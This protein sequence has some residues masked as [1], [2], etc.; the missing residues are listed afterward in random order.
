[1]AKTTDK[2][3]GRGRKPKQQE[4][5]LNQQEGLTI[6]TNHESQKHQNEKDIETSDKSIEDIAE[7]T[8]NNK[9]IPNIYLT[10][11]AQRI[12]NRLYELYG[13]SIKGDVCR[14]MIQTAQ[15]YAS[16]EN[17]NIQDDIQEIKIAELYDNILNILS[18]GYAPSPLDNAYNNILITAIIDKYKV[19]D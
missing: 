12:M 9:T 13:Y 18:R 14:K 5:Q 11:T 7:K 8:Q 2:N 16:R 19:R 6:E 1:M 10:N 3:K 4:V 17:I 15:S